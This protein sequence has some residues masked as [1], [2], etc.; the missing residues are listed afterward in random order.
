M[1]RGEL[2]VRRRS[3][4]VPRRGEL[5]IDTAADVDGIKLTKTRET[6]TVTLDDGTVEMLLRHLDQMD[7]RAQQCGVEIAP[8]AFVFSLE[9]DCSRPMPA[10]YVTKRV[11]VLKEHLGIH[12]KRPTTVALEDEAL[13]LFRGK[14]S[15][16]PTGR[17]GP[18][19]KGALSYDEIGRRL[20]RSGRWAAMAIA[21]AQ[22]REAA[23]AR[24][25]IEIFDG[26]ILGLR[27]FTSSELLDAGFNIS[28]VALRQGHGPQV[29]AR[30]YSKARRSADR[31]AAEHLGRLIHI[32]LRDAAG[33]SLSI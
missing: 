31:K 20:R 32:D 23:Q 13:A 2:T 14:S 27:K 1:R 7:Q 17:R 29:L 11:A 16:R 10:D 24:G 15:T 22:R 19:P 21:S 33:P 3:Q 12:D 30:H 5:E 18:R 4:F 26:S 6:R 9:P 28:A 25:D 8:D